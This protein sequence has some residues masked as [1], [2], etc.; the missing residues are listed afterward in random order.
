MPSEFGLCFANGHAQAIFCSA[1]GHPEHE[2]LSHVSDE[3]IDEF[4][5]DAFDV[6]V[7]CMLFGRAGGALG[8]TEKSQ[9]ATDVV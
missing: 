6:S 7:L 5:P 3:A 1:S 9:R 8:E 4:V 2:V